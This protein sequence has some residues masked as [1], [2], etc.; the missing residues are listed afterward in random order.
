MITTVSFDL[1][2]APFFPPGID[3]L[4][5]E[6]FTAVI[7]RCS[8]VRPMVTSSTRSGCSLAKSEIKFSIS[9]S[10]WYD[11]WKVELEN[12]M[13]QP[14]R[15]PSVALVV[16]GGSNPRAGKSSNGNLKGGGVEL[17]RK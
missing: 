7:S 3:L 16:S 1:S 14:A 2:D 6:I 9:E 4:A 12:D 11:E 5:S 15:F 13:S 17:E 10:G 8:L